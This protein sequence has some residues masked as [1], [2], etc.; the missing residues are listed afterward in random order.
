MRVCP[1]PDLQLEGI[2]CNYTK[3]LLTNLDNI[4]ASHELVY[5]LST[6]S[7]HCFTN[8][9]V[10]HE[11]DEETQLISKLEEKISKLIKESKQPEVIELL[12]LAS[13][14]PLYRYDWCQN[15]ESLDFLKRGKVAINFGAA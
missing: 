2:L 11:K 8:E 1:L 3:F 15:L 6:L 12:C 4:K 10:Y 14:R 13:Y 9:Y 7:L 5:F